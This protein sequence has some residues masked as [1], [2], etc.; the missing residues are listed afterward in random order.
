MFG[1]PG[2]EKC[3]ND[4][5]VTF[6]RQITLFAPKSPLGKKCVL[7][8]KGDFGE[9]GGISTNLTLY[10]IRVRAFCG[11]WVSRDAKWI[12]MSIS[13]FHVIFMKS[14]LYVFTTFRAASRKTPSDFATPLML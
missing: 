4:P 5:Q 8:L 14:K 1:A 2:A 10:F 13:T 12:L 3:E 6:S 11:F 7:D 9:S